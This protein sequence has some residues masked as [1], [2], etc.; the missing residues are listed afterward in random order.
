MLKDY[1]SHVISDPF[2]T[3][4]YLIS[5]ISSHI[6][7]FCLQY[8]RALGKH[9]SSTTLN[10]PANLHSCWINRLWTLRNIAVNDPRPK[11]WRGGSL[12]PLR[13]SRRFFSR[14]R[15]RPF[16][17]IFENSAEI[18]SCP[19]QYKNLLQGRLLSL[20]SPSSRQ[21]VRWDPLVMTSMHTA[22]TPRLLGPDTV[23]GPGLWLWN[24]KAFPAV[25]FRASAKDVS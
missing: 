6:T 22:L 7:W 10:F 8:T 18:A 11:V 21:M 14:A 16:P 3:T 17:R 15:F 12:G 2:S 9:L 13:E 4:F 5:Y 19:R 24:A 20:S 1:S 25:A 23:N